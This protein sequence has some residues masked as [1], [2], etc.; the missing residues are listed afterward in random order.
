V[1]VNELSLVWHII[2]EDLAHLLETQSSSLGEE[3][4]NYEGAAD[5]ESNKDWYISSRTRYAETV[6][7]PM[8]YLAPIAVVAEGE[9]V[10]QTHA[11]AIYTAIAKDIPLAR[12]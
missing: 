10:T 11:D 6:C 2:A 8:L 9:V 1:L 4:V 12:M 7:S 5:G 3:E